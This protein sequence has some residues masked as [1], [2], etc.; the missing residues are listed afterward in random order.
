MNDLDSNSNIIPTRKSSSN[1]RIIS[2]FKRWFKVDKKQLASLG[3]NFVLSYSI[4]STING[5]AS[6][7]F[8]WYFASIKVSNCG[9]ILLYID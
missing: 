1:N 3:V 2:K 4:V 8:A 7:S 9:I 5:A 6:L